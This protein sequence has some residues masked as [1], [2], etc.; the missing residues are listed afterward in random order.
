M[1]KLSGDS[2]AFPQ[3]TTN[4][5]MI[6]VLIDDC[7]DKMTQ[8]TAAERVMEKCA[9]DEDACLTAASFEYEQPAAY[10][11]GC[12][13]TGARWQSERDMK[14]ITALL[15][16]AQRQDEALARVDKWTIDPKDKLVDEAFQYE[17]ARQF[18]KDRCAEARADFDKTILALGGGK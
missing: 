4:G 15:D 13:I 18:I 10:S 9:F 3:I 12:F 11:A 5:E 7:M 16:L 1:T 8:P 2:P 6:A 17:G 14:V